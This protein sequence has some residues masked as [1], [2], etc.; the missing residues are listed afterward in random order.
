MSDDVTRL[1]LDGDDA[2]LDRALRELGPLMRR[3]ELL[4]A[5]EP[6]AAFA[7]DLRARLVDTT[8]NNLWC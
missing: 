1:E 2:A 7:R 6:N 5:A 8:N 4:D 3:Q